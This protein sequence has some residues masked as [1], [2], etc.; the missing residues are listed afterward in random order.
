MVSV[1][2]GVRRLGIAF[3]I[4][5]ATNVEKSNSRQKCNVNIQILQCVVCTKYIIGKSQR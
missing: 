3:I 4:I 5:T 2:Y 1:A